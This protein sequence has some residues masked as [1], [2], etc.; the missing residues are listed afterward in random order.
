MED[1]GMGEIQREIN[2]RL[3]MDPSPKEDSS[4]PDLCFGWLVPGHSRCQCQGGPCSVCARHKADLS[5][6]VMQAEIHCK[7][8]SA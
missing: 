3:S 7:K 6:I 1:I 2:H 4:P 5:D 8:R